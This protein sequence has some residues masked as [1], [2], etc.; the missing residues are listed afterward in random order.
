[1]RFPVTI[2]RVLASYLAGSYA[3]IVLLITTEPN[4]R[5]IRQD[6]GCEAQGWHS[7][8]R[9]ISCSSSLHASRVLCAQDVLQCIW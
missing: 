3:A 8:S 6:M 7:M 4:S 9:A 2:D 1:M 5:C